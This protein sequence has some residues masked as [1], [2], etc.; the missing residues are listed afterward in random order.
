MFSI[1]AVA[2]GGSTLQVGTAQPFDAFGFCD[3]TVKRA[4]GAF[5]LVLFDAQGRESAA[6]WRQLDEQTVDSTTAEFAGLLELVSTALAQGVKSLWVGLDS[7]QV[8]EHAIKRSVRYEAFLTPLLQM[9][10]R[11]DH[12]QLQAIARTEN[13]RADAL[14]RKGIAHL[15]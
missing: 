4:T 5:G 10:D 8:I 13:K 14:A 6:E 15:R 2:R 11:F 9:L 1:P 3:G 12:V 7:F